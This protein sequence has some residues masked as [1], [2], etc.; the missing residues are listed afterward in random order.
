MVD[1]D[2]LIEY[3]VR[4]FGVNGSTLDLIRSAAGQ[5]PIDVRTGRDG[6]TV[7]SLEIS[8][9]TISRKIGKLLRISRDGLDFDIFIS[10]HSLFGSYVLEIPAHVL[11]I[12][13]LDSCR[14]FISYTRITG[15]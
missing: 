9:E 15:D 3:F 5:H 2:I 13:A 1:N 14:S 4:I 7:H 8:D 12:M 10:L 6:K 11:E